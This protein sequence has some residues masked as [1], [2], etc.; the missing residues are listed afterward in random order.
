MHTSF[1]FTFFINDYVQRK[2]LAMATL[3]TL[4]VHI[5][6]QRTSLE[7]TYQNFAN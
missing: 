7:L 3:A 6:T 2:T 5:Y 1:K 4:A